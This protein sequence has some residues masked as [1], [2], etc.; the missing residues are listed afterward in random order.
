MCS[1]F[2]IHGSS[3]SSFEV[4]S[5]LLHLQHRGQDAAG[6]ASFDSSEKRL[7]HFKDLGLV[8][9]VFNKDILQELKGEI[10]IGHTRYATTGGASRVDIQP[11]LSGFPIGMALA[12]NGNLHNYH[13]LARKLSSDH[14]IQLL[15]QN[16][17]ELIQHII[18]LS[19]FA[20]KESSFFSKLVHAAGS[21]L[22]K[23]KGAFALIGI[24]SG[25]GLFGLRD[26]NGIRPLVL[27][28]RKNI[29]EK[30][31]D[32]VQYCLSSET[33][34][35]NVLGFEYVR[36][37]EPGELIF[38]D[39]DKNLRSVLISKKSHSPCMFEWVYFSAAESTI[40]NMGVYQARLNLGSFLANKIDAK[41]FDIVMPVPDTGRTAAIALAEKAKLPYREG[42][43]KNRYVQR[44]FILAQNEQRKAAVEQK[45][46]PVISEI[47]G[48]HILLVDDSLVRGTT[49][50]RIIDLLKRF[51][52]SSVSMA[53]TCPPIRFG[54]FYGIDF[55]SPQELLAGNFEIPK[56]AQEIGAREIFYL[57]L[58]DLKEALGRSDLC[59]GCLTG[60][61]PTK[62][63]G[64]EE[65]LEKRR[66]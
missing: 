65:F 5:A 39:N 17:L 14:G 63:K 36:D 52:A 24:I 13:E 22:E 29:D 53:F 23:C 33:V 57:D 50:K 45:L 25:K 47:K 43:I 54:C 49:S 60:T 59:T 42:L 16:D 37:I 26:P 55:P 41:K 56:I 64:A 66:N 20:D 6:I 7:T 31:I 18:S 10:S 48:K 4:Y 51:G 1:L 12:H 3:N 32:Q 58:V 38:I 62:L 19:F 11:L 2:G 34:A 15:T 46:S 21:V 28:I 35:L 9:A 40:E 30:G 44:S 61:Y 27:G 8:N